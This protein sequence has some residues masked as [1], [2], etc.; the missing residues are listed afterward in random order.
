MDAP[1]APAG[2]PPRRGRGAFDEGDL[3]SFPVHS[4][5]R[6]AQL[7]Y[8]LACA[9]L[10]VW[11]ARDQARRW[12]VSE[13]IGFNLPLVLYAGALGVTVARVRGPRTPS[14]LWVPALVLVLL[15][16]L[17]GL[18]GGTVLA[19]AGVMRFDSGS[20]EGIV[21]VLCWFALLAG[22]FIA[23]ILIVCSRRAWA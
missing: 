4:L 22:P 15:H 18:A 10:A 7:A 3:A 8:L 19:A 20:G 14:L 16:A 21:F 9:V 13:L 1:S 2:P 17:T 23:G 12:V 6:V 5:Q 11:T